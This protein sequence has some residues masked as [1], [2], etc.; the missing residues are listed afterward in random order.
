MNDEVNDEALALV[1]EMRARRRAIE[2]QVRHHPVFLAS[3]LHARI[4]QKTR[5]PA[6]P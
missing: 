6:P 5:S 2:E 4:P 1:Q 3:P